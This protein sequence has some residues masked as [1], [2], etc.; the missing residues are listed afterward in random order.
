MKTHITFVESALTTNSPLDD[1]LFFV[2]EQARTRSLVQQQQ[3][4]EVK[5]EVLE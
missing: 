2:R 4:K 1:Q 3:L 5:E